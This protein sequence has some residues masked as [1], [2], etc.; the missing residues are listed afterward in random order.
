MLECRVI[1]G[2]NAF[3]HLLYCASLVSVPFDLFICRSSIF[4]VVGFN[5]EMLKSNPRSLFEH[6]NEDHVTVVG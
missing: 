3:F 1:I 2:I 4:M 5:V 6:L